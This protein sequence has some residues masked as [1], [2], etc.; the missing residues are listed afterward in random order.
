[1]MA[2]AVNLLA[3]IRRLGGDVKLISCDK[4][5]L[6]APT[7]LMPEL[8]ERVRAAKPMLVAVLLDD[9][10]PAQQNGEGVSCPPSNRAT[11]QHLPAEAS[12]DI[13]VSK[14]AADWPARH[15]EALAHWSVFY[16]PS[17]AAR[18]A[19]GEIENHWHM[20]HGERLPDWQCAGC[21]EFIDGIEALTLGDGNRAH[22]VTLDCLLRYGARWRGS[23]TR[24]LVAMGLRAPASDDAR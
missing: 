13:S 8:A 7:A 4:L 22:L 1:M 3:E 5:R 17:E 9:T 18:L 20:Q 15:R 11:V 6:V 14:A 2:D 19:W 16:A 24:A 12:S 10:S 21:G 23:A